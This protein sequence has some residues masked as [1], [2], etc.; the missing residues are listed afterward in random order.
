MI[1]AFAHPC[2]VVDD[3]ELAREFYEEAFGFRVINREGWQDA[4]E[5]DA[6]I[7]SSNSRSRGYMMAGHN[8]FL[9]LFEFDAPEQRGPDPADLGPHERGIR[10]LSFYVDDCR[11]EY[12]RCLALG[13][14]PL[15]TPAPPEIGI[16]AVYL[17]DP[18]GNIVELCEIPRPEEE[19]TT[20]PGIDRLNEEY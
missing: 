1:L 8:C 9:E 4:P 20:L 2:L 19:P 14:R 7:G 12:R 10:H 15:G 16:N 18:C 5:V 17:R 11:A 6:A 13:A 3:V